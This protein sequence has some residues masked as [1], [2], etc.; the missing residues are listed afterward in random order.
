MTRKKSCKR[1]GKR[2]FRSA[3]AVLLMVGSIG[4]NLTQTVFAADT[5]T[6]TYVYTSSATAD[7]KLKLCSSHAGDRLDGNG[8]KMYDFLKG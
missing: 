7:Q 5:D 1:G 6:Q 8:K 4:W 2:A 3:A